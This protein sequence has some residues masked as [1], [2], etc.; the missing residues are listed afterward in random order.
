[1]ADRDLNS[2]PVDATATPA[3]A[4]A[5]AAPLE[6]VRRLV[7]AI[8]IGSSALRLD[9]GEIGT[10][11]SVRLLES[12]RHGVRL[13]KDVFT[14]G[15]VEQDTMRRCVAIMKNYS[16]LLKEYGVTRPDQVRAVATSFAREA[17]N[18]D[19]FVDRISTATG[20]AV[21]VLE[22]SEESRLTFLAVRELLASGGLLD[23]RNVVVLEIGG[24]QTILL[25]I[26]NRLVTVAQVFRAGALRTR[27]LV[28]AAGATGA[29]LKG[30]L[31]AYAMELVE[32]IHQAIPAEKISALVVMGAGARFAVEQGGAVP[33]AAESRLAVVPAAKLAEVAEQVA[34][35]AVESLVRTHKMAFQDAETVAPALMSLTQVARALK[36]KEL[37]IARATLRDGLLGEMAMREHLAVGYEEQVIY[38]AQ[39]LAARYGMDAA[40]AQNVTV[41]AL[42]LFDELQEEHQLGSHARLLLRCAA[43]LHDI[44]QFVNARA[45]HKHSLYLIQNS[46][47]FGLTRHD[48]Q[49]VATVSRYH[50]KALPSPAHPEFAM[51]SQDDRMTVAKLAAILRV[52]DALERTHREAP[53]PMEFRREGERF[54]IV[55]RN[56]EDLTMERLAL[57]DKGNLF[58]DV[59]G[60]IP[61]LREV[62]T[63]VPGGVTG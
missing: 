31:K 30:V 26:R 55:L 54:V 22:E 58:A 2:S 27:E 57:K 44:G 32:Q 25:Y 59:F 24:G 41:G 37:H 7:A 18:R 34:P 49:I 28:T 45:H 61:E 14:K 52:A 47:L 63:D 62:R 48:M 5:P 4:P 17:A 15:R 33:L 13:G 46:E 38:S 60:M 36:V 9:I 42:A 29:Q 8:D 3:T 12:L 56:M 39:T 10:Q 16:R 35:L 11:G 23:A 51:L 40:H 19:M 20:I 21:N 53:R 1:M 50:R 43:I 6:M